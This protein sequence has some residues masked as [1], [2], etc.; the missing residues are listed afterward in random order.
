VLEDECVIP[1]AGAFEVACSAHLKEYMVDVKGRAKLGVQAFADA[2]LV[3]PK[4]LSDNGGHDPQDTVIALIEE[5]EAGKLAGVNL[6]DGGVLDPMEAGIYDAY[7]VKKQSL[8]LT[9]VIASQF[10]LTDEILKA[11][12]KMG[13]GGPSMPG[14]N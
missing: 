4:T 3:I 8:H 9:S 10:L 5:H 11:G 2:M 1:G 6:E 13:K 12:K 7:M 14:M